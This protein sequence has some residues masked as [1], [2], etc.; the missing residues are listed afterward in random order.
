MA[1]MAEALGMAL[2]GNAA[3]PA[4]DS[5]RRMMAHMS[6]RR[7]VEVVKDD[8]N[9]FSYPAMLAGLDYSLYRHSR[10]FSVLEYGMVTRAPLTV[11]TGEVGPPKGID[12]EE[13]LHGARAMAHRVDAVAVRCFD[14]ITELQTSLPW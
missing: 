5:R 6:G 1:S 9:E 11:V 10:A 12:T 13:V 7:I 3:I 14:F 4:V 2:S 8:L